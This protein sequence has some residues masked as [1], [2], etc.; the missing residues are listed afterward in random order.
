VLSVEGGVVPT[1]GI[2]GRLQRGATS[3]MQGKSS[4]VTTVAVSTR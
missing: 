3:A 1:L 4:V 2:E